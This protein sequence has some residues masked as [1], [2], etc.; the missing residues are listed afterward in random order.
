M[1]RKSDN[2]GHPN[3]IIDLRRGCE[4]TISPLSTTYLGFLID[5]FYLFKKV[6]FIIYCV[7]KTYT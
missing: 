3:L 4:L 5:L 1:L 7:L 6:L 2:I